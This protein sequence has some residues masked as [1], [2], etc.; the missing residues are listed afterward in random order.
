MLYP[1]LTDYAV[2]NERVSVMQIHI[3]HQLIIIIIIII[4]IILLSW[5]D[6]ATDVTAAG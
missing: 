2:Y 3:Q 5:N 4:I 6:D 1:C